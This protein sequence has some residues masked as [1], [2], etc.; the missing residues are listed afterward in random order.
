ADSDG[1]LFT[2]RIS[3]ADHPWLAGHAVFGTV[4]L[5]GVAYVEMALHAAHRLGLE[6][7]DELTL[8]APLALPESG[9]VLVQ[10]SV[11]P[12]DESGRRAFTFHSRNEHAPSD[13]SW[14]RHAS[15]SLAPT[16]E[17][18]AFDLRV[19]PPTGAVLVP[20]DGLYE[21]LAAGG[22]AYGPA[23]Q[24]LRAV[25]KRG[26]ELFAEAEL[27]PAAEADAARFALHPALFDSVLH[28]IA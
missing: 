5:P 22:L 16:V 14:T 8:E 11:A 17:T 28:A 18:P 19:W 12:L 21:A 1:L 3:L 20:I 25:W 23:F 26:D 2:G 15:G 6:L 10:L 7:V 13:Q 9:A 24:G 4:I 27:S